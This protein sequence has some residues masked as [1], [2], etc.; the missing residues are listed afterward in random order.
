MTITDD[1]IL[2]DFDYSLAA[3]KFKG[4]WRFFCDIEQM[5][6]LDYTLYD[7]DYVPEPGGYR[8][9]LLIID[10]HN[11]EQ[12]MSAL[13]VE[14]TA[15]QLMHLYREGHIERV[16]L[17]F[18]I[19][20]DEKLWVGSM[21]LMDQSALDEYQ[22]ADWLADADNVSKYLPEEI[23]RLFSKDQLYSLLGLPN[24]DLAVVA[25]AK[26]TGYLLNPGHET[27][28]SKAAYFMAF[29]FSAAACGVMKAALLDHA[30]RY[31]VK[32]I[33]PMKLGV[34]FVI[35]GALTCPDGRTPL[36]TAVWRIDDGSNV[37]RFITAYP[38]N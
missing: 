30:A 2:S 34:H 37:P 32:T 29:G 18:V 21:W 31:N 7:S 12:W 27:G 5:F 15:A 35:E 17:T 28:A 14:V 22:P 38:G 20:F 16:K 25:E 4:R 26:I 6:L 10:E 33:L 8:D 9:G 13:A 24:I 19:N 23:R 3:V 36:V 11:A 1:L